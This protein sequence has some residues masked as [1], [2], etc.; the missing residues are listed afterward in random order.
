VYELVV[1]GCAERTLRVALE[2]LVD[3]QP[4]AGVGG[5]LA[6]R[7]TDQ[8][9]LVAA[10]ERLHDLGVVIENVHHVG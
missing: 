4:H 3:E 7:V 1:V 5:S 2:D 8:A 6:V 10:I 9:R